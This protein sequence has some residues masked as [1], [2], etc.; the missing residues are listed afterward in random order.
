MILKHTNY[1]YDED[2]NC[3]LVYSISLMAREYYN[4]TNIS[5]NIKCK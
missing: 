3:L 2:G 1:H 4:I 5:M